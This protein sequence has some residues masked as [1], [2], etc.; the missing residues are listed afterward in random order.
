MIAAKTSAALDA[1]AFEQHYSDFAW[2]HQTRDRN[3]S[4]ADVPHRARYLCQLRHNVLGGRTGRSA[5]S[6]LGTNL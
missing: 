3:Y 5:M 4:W 2:C 1:V 6:N